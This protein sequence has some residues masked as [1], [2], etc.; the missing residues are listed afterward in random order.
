MKIYK[1]EGRI[2]KKKTRKGNKV[3]GRA[4]IEP[5]LTPVKEEEDPEPE[6]SVRLMASLIL[7]PFIN[8]SQEKFDHLSSLPNGFWA[9]ILTAH[10]ITSSWM[11]LQPLW[12]PK[13]LED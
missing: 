9:N 13:K 11:N 8:G 7:S 12:K 6:T 1:K 5:K 2:G 4:R 3:D 10:T